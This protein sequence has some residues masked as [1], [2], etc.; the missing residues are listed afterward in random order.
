MSPDQP[1]PAHDDVPRFAARLLGDFAG[2]D[3]ADALAATLDTRDLELQRAAADSLVRLGQ[4][5]GHLPVAVTEIVAGAT[6][7]DTDREVRLLATRALGAAARAEAGATLDALLD[8]DDPFV[9]AEAARALA[10]LGRP[11]GIERL[12]ADRDPMVRSAAAEALAQLGGADVV[13]RLV[14]LVFA[15]EGYHARAAGR[16]LRRL[17]PGTATSHLLAVLAEPGAAP[18]WCH[19]I[20]ALEEL[21]RPESAAL[22]EAGAA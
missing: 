1:V 10:T 12:L 15:F 19:A 20:E 8:D 22:T 11:D 2:D 16:L 5:M 13:T 9:R 6:R 3:V 7:A 4:R 17:D 18:R 14:H 21:H